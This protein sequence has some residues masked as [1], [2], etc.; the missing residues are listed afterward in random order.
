MPLSDAKC[1]SA[2]A[3][4]RAV[5]LFDGEGLYLEVAPSGSK[6]WRLKYRYAGREK[7]IS[8]GTYPAVPLLQARRRKD[9]ACRL[10]AQGLDPSAQ[11]HSQK[12]AARAARAN[13]FEAVARQWHASWSRT[14]SA[15]RA[16]QVLRRLEADVFLSLGHLAV[17]AI[18]SPD[19]VAAA[20]AVESREA[21]V[22]A[23]RVIQMCSQVLRYAIAHG[24]AEHNP[25]RDIIPSD[26]L[27][28]TRKRNPPR[29]DAAR[30]PELLQAIDG[31][32]GHERTRLAMHLLALTFV[33]TSELT[34]ARWSEFDLDAMLWR[35]PAERMKMKTAHMVSLSR[36]AIE[37]LLALKTAGADEQLL[38]PS[39]GAN[40]DHCRRWQ[41]L[42]WPWLALYRAVASIAAPEHFA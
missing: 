7:R 14:R 9:D 22:I 29:I 12:L 36:Q 11:R 34:Q 40:H 13:S 3:G 31:Y 19:I 10:L 27:E 32:S 23:R 16:T 21:Q 20:R 8:L 35:I 24:M 15:R 39:E 30:L 4:E 2:K 26:T 37:V 25:A 1:R 42:H 28:P 17:T 38:F 6:G 41:R 33:R 5:K 18:R